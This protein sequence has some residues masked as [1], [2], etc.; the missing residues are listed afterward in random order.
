MKQSLLLLEDVDAL[1]RS[2]DIVSVKAGFAR[3]FLIPQK[4]ALHASKQTIKLQEKLKEERIKRAAV[5]RKEAEELA[6]SIEGTLLTIEVKVDADGNLYGSVIAADI[7]ALMKKEGIELDKKN[8][9]LPKPIKSLGKYSIQLRLK[10]NVPASIQLE[11][12][13]EGGMVIAEK[14]KRKKKSVEVQV[15]E[16]AEK[17]KEYEELA[18]EAKE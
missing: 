3:N 13:P 5:D 17:V 10:E 8:V 15:E 9:I 2:G 11:V 14:R 1:G 16:Q 12:K 6:T 7:L 4:K 18:D